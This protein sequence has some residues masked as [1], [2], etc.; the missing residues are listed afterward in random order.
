MLSPDLILRLISIGVLLTVLTTGLTSGCSNL[1][2]LPTQV[3]TATKVDSSGVTGAS[4]TRNEPVKAAEQVEQAIAQNLPREIGVPIQSVS[5]PDGV[6]LEAGKVFDCK[7]QIPQG[8]FPIRVTVKD[9]QGTLN[10]RTQGI[11]LLSEAE[12][13]L[14]QSIKKREGMDIKADC[15]D[16]V[17]PFKKVGERFQCKLTRPDGKTGTATITVI[18]EEGKVDAKW[19][20]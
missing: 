17:K 11:L 8:N 6:I 16:K 20:L 5:C 19:K 18:S 2:R 13:Q 9:A 1:V 3:E 14:Q 10:F 12:T 7:A 15:G 4:V